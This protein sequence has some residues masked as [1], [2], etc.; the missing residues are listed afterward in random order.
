MSDSAQLG[1]GPA[2]TAAYLPGVRGHAVLA[3]GPDAEGRAALAAWQLNAAGDAVG[4]W[5]I[6]IEADPLRVGGILFGLR[7]CA[8]VDWDRSGPEAT[9]GHVARLLPGGLAERLLSTSLALPSL[10]AEIRARRRRCE[11]IVQVA[12]GVP[13]PAPIRESVVPVEIGGGGL[14]AA[15]WRRNIWP[16]LRRPR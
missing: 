1:G 14:G 10:L 13:E 7:G 5:E 15:L 2:V 12:V 11:E 16:S 8:L 3:Y 9:L 6:P 4:S